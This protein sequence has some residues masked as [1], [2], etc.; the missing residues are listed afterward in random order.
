LINSTVGDVRGTMVSS[1]DADSM[2]DHALSDLAGVM[3]V[4]PRCC[5]TVYDPTAADDNEDVHPAR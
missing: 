1:E 3:H 2:D 4:Q 5:F